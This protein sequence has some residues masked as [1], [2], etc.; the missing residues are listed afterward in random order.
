MR[1][2]LTKIIEGKP[3]G[4][5]L[6]FGVVVGRFN[7]FVT[8]KLLEGALEALKGC[9]VEDE[10][11]VVVRVPGSFEVPPAA[12]KLAD[13]GRFHAVVCLGAII[14]GETPHWD[15]LGRTVSDAI[16]RIA[17]ESGVPLTFG[18]LTTETRDT[19]LARAEERGENRGYNAAIAA[20]EMADLYRQMEG[21]REAPR[22]V[23]GGSVCC[24]EQGIIVGW[25]RKGRELAVQMLYQ[26]EISEEPVAR[27]QESF[28]S[29]REAA[30][31]TRGLAQR[32]L[33]GTV[34]HLGEIDELLTKHAEHW[35]LPRMA[36]VDRNILRLAI[37]EFLYEEVPKRVVINEALEVT[38]RFSSPDA[39]QFVNGVLD[40]VRSSLEAPEAS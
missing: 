13:S 24:P 40:A 38:K 6:R 35:R 7:N 8:D 2:I 29:L 27:V 1:A 17:L 21:N 31:K 34:E 23:A 25:R 28:W 10:D 5:G 39:V 22:S 37:Y 12:K 9:G 4:T 3:S 32:L 14:K 30:D 26:W 20:V 15:Y 33:T 16:A 36:A 19:A 18:I 11:M